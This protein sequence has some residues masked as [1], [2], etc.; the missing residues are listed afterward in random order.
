MLLT[1]EEI[2]AL[3]QTNISSYPEKTKER[4]QTLWK[5]ASL[6][7]KENLCSLAGVGIPTIY[8]VTK[9]GSLSAKLAIA[10]A[11]TFNVNPH[12][13]LGETDEQGKCNKENVHQLLEQHG[14][15]TPSV[16]PKQKDA[17][18]QLRAPAGAFASPAKEEME[19]LPEDALQDLLHALIIRSNVTKS[20]EKLGRLQ[21]ILLS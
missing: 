14:Y 9:V 10:I 13:L 17:P 7:Q 4:V 2:Q 20:N 12:Y 19:I 11:Q 5:S 8:R 6:E 21:K 3:K 16:Q 18:K 15:R 1:E